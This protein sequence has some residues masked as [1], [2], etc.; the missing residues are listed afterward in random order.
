VP[1]DPNVPQ[2][3]SI[4]IEEEL[5]KSYVNYAMSVIIARALPDVRDGLKPVQRRIL[6][7]MRELN[8]TPNNATT[9]CAKV[10]GETQA[11]Y[12]PHG[13][14][15][16]YPTLVRL[17]QPFSMRYPLVDG[18]GNF[19][20]IDG[21]PAAA[22]RYTECRLT[23]LAMEL[24]EDLERETVDWIETYLQEKQEPTVLPGKFPNLLC[25]GGQGIAVGMATSM[26]PHNLGEVCNAILHRIDNSDCTLEDVMQHLPGPDFPT[27]GLIMGKKGI[28]DAY[29]TGRG[30]VVM[31]AKTMIEP[32]DNGKTAI[33]VSEIPYQVNKKNLVKAIADLARAKKFDGI[34]DVQDYSDKR[35]LRIQID[36]RRDVNP[37]KAL[38][39]LLKHTALRTSFSCIMLSL[40]DNAPRVSPLLVILDE[41]IRHRK[42]VIERRVR[43]DLYRALEEIHMNE[44]YQ[45]ARRFLDGVIKAIR[46]SI[47]ANEA[48]A[49]LIRE[50]GMSPLQA[51]GV[52][53]MPLRRLTQLEQDQLE[54]AYKDVLRK[55]QDLM[56]ILA[57]PARLIL[58]LKNEIVAMRDKFADERRTRIIEREAGDFSEEDLIPE[59]EA[60]ISISRDGY[61][62]R[63][64]LDA[65]RQQKRGGKGM[66]NVQKQDDEPA[67]L[68]Q[69]NTHHFVLFFTDRG[70]VFKLRAYDLP[71]SGR[72]QRG[73][74]V[75]NYIAMDGNERVTAT[76]SVKDIK[77][78]GFLTMITR[79]GEIKRTAMEKFANIRSNGLIAFDIEEG[80][81]L[82][83]VLATKGE[84]DVILVTRRGLSIRFHEKA[85]RDRGRQAGGVRAI[86]LGADDII[87]SADI[88]DDAMDLLVVGQNG[89]GKRTPLSDY[90]VQGRGGKGILTMNVTA[91]TGEIIG[92]EVVEG[93]DR[94]LLLTTNGKGIRLRV[95][96]VRQVGRIAQGVKLIDLAAGDSIASIARIIQSPDG[97]DIDGEDEEE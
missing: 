85:A 32:L 15:V 29:E 38:N 95:K 13:Q 20:S 70:R 88:A 8:L 82:G 35:G 16:I 56:D 68:F 45:I 31:Q 43:F 42:K 84:Q 81:E 69:V 79:Q 39:Y 63:I 83:W 46:E 28:R 73:M 75:I 71:E 37:N 27:Y 60:I 41:Y 51:N 59:E 74:P 21:D 52:L 64:S 19:G 92:A 78:E 11:N 91:K 24:L 67:H 17:A 66:K 55:A 12:H 77:A 47:D 62:K 10:A 23:P 26:P 2:I 7:A 4:E 93:E 5:A 9:K 49:R 6:Y 54:K 44:G 30:S 3:G 94:L 86:T 76:V 33:I 48:R 65:Y 53:A 50:F 18:Q 36:L 80:D 22:M 34:T 90:R 14:E 87:V 25:N 40:V 61:I 57:S 97:G 89:F 58:E 1:E 72:Y 96:E